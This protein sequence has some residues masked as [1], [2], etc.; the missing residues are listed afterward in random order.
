M[1]H[2]TIG[3][4]AFDGFNAALMV[5]LALVTL[6]PLVF[7]LFASL[8]DPNAVVQ[9][10]G[11]LLYPK[12]LTLEAYKL[13]FANPNIATA[14][15]NTLIYVVCGTAVNIVMTSLGAYAL[16]RRNVMWKNTIMF[17]IVF[18]MFFEGG[19]IPLYLLV[20]NL[21]MLDSR[22]ALI[23]PTAVSAFNLIIM[24]TAFQGVPVSLEESARLDG[25]SDWTILAR[26]V[27]P[28]SLPVVAV[29]VLF[30]GVYHWNSWF[31]AMIYLQTRELFPLQLILR[32]ILI[33]NDT[34][35]MIGSV[36]SSDSMPIGET[37]KYATIIVATL[38]ILF[39]YPFLQKYFV[40][41]VM[42]GAVKE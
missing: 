40:K 1:M 10:R 30:Y 22:L 27:L 19:L 25:A 26:V 2:K 42:I 3:E 21:G 7:V 32:E 31:P 24:R 4:R 18:T 20:G 23:I 36:A 28:L 17:L 9:N 34:G 38:P 12:G 29:M 37:I 41:G 6:Y 35:S 33:A 13:V 8:S 16:S 14:Y 39:L 15:V 11:L 5:A